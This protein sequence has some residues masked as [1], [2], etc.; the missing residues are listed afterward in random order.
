MTRVFAISDI[1]VDYSENLK[2]IQNLSEF[3]YSKD[4]LILAGDVTD[5]LPLMEKTFL[6]LRDKFKNVLYV[7]GNHDLWIRRSEETCSFEKFH[8]IHQI[9]RQCDVITSPYR[10]NDT[11]FVP[12]YSWYDFSFGDLD[13]SIKKRWADFRA[14]QWSGGYTE[15]E[16][17][18]Y[19]HSLNNMKI[20]RTIL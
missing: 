19:F 13:P 8:R 18:T 2:W 20:G 15:K 6:N 17:T 10:Y 9:A 11:Y 5:R 3:E 14:C 4:I 7:P 12:L 16:I 1:H